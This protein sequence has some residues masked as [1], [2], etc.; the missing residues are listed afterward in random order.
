MRVHS[1]VHR[2]SAV[3]PIT[4]QAPFL[5]ETVGTPCFGEQLFR[6]ARDAVRCDHINAF[7]MTPCARPRMIFAA[8]RRAPIAWNAGTRYLSHH[9]DEDPANRIVAS[10]PLPADGILVRMTAEDM[11]ASPYRRDLYT[12]E[13]WAE[14]GANL[15]ERLSIVRR[16]KHEIVR[17]GFYRHKQFGPFTDSEVDTITDATD[18]LFAL[19]ARHGVLPVDVAEDIALR[20]KYEQSLRQVAPKLSRRET[21]VCACI[22]AGL[23]SEAIALELGIS[24][25][26]VLTHRKHSYA[27]LN[28]SSQNQLL[29]LIYS[30]MVRRDH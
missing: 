1:L 21:E 3:D 23:N 4:R 29:K 10:N 15:I 11:A 26:T 12:P 28:I 16:C 5:I 18:L 27:R 14:S 30:A 6:V 7:A 9:W 24:L 25:N 19:T 20:D 8:S 17:I 2:R 22:A 13:A